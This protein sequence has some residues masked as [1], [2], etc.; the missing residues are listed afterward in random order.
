MPTSASPSGARPER[1]IFTRHEGNGIDAGP[2]Y[3]RLCAPVTDLLFLDPASK[4]TLLSNSLIHLRD[5]TASCTFLRFALT[6]R[7]QSRPRGDDRGAMHSTDATSA[8]DLAAQ[9]CSARG[10]HPCVFVVVMNP[11]YMSGFDKARSRHS[12][13]HLCNRR[14]RTPTDPFAERTARLAVRFSPAMESC[15]CSTCLGGTPRWLS[16][17]TNPSI[18]QAT[19]PTPALLREPVACG[20]RPPDGSVSRETRVFPSAGVPGAAVTA[21]TSNPATSTPCSV[22]Q[23]A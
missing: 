2:G 13:P 9:S 1:S 12:H 14:H 4:D 7:G 8:G 21:A 19:T 18:R 15:W 6:N 10:R 3:D 22:S 20:S 16:R 5:T 11:A 17:V 23:A